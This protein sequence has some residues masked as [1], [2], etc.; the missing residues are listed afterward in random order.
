[1]TAPAD[2]WVV[3]GEALSVYPGLIEALSTVGI[4]GAVPIATAVTAGRGV[5]GAITPQLRPVR[6]L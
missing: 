5:R 4:P 2:A 1:M 6:S 3:K